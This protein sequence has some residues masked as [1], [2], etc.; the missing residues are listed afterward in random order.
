MDRTDTE[1]AQFVLTW[2]PY[3]WPPADR[4]FVEFGMSAAR[5]RQRCLQIVA[6]ASRGTAGLAPEQARLVYWL[7]ETLRKGPVVSRITV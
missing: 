1:I 7:A 2:A 5:L 6:A 3:G 4:I